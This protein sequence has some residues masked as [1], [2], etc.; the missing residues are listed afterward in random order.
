M[1]EQSEHREETGQFYWFG[2][3]IYS[4]MFVQYVEL[5]TPIL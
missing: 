1:W 2:L 5:L 3:S 4:R